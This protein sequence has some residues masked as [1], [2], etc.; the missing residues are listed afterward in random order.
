MSKPFI[1]DDGID[2][3]NEARQQI[4][5]PMRINGE[6]PMFDYIKHYLK[7]GMLCLDVG[8]NIGR[9]VYLFDMHKLI[10]EG[11]D[12]SPTAIELARKIFPDKVFYL[13]NALDMDF[14][15]KYDLVFT[16]T[17]MQHVRRGNQAIIFKRMYR[18]LKPGGL[19]IMRELD[20][21]ESETHHT[22]EVWLNMLSS[23]G[24][25]LMEY[26]P[27]S[28]PGTNTSTYVMKK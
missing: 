27:R 11:L 17:V 12:A 21:S 8:C 19:Y 25:K 28:H 10:Y 18:A 20:G 6:S 15:D 24:F 1:G 13:M 26:F 7:P 14:T 16:N 23:T 9:W 2:W 22:E 5:K 3:D 4:G